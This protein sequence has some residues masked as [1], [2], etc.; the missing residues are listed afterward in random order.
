MS[1]KKTNQLY[2]KNIGYN[3]EEICPKEKILFLDIETTGLSPRSSYIYMIGA[4]H[5]TEASGLEPEGYTITQ[6]LAENA[7]DEK[8]ILV[9]FLSE[10][11]NYE[12]LIHFNGNTF[13]LPFIQARCEANGLEFNYSEFK[14]IDIYR[15]IQPFKN[16]LRLGSCKQKAVEEYLGIDREDQYSGGQLVGVYK[17][18][19]KSA[20]R[21]AL[22]L[23]VTHNYEDVTGMLSILPIL[24]YSDFLSGDNI[25]VGKVQINTYK[26]VNGLKSREL[27]INLTLSS[28]L[29]KP[30]SYNAN[31]CILTARA[32]EASLKVPVYDEE[33][34]YFYEGYKDYYYLPEEDMAVHKSVSIYVD[35]EFR[36]QATASTCYTRKKSSYLPEWGPLFNPFFKRDYETKSMFFELN[37]EFK[38]NKSSFIDYAKHILDM[39]MRNK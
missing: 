21:K 26:D 5:Y 19:V 8:E 12:M 27:L 17:E 13:D 7:A 32:N 33:M 9:D 31:E 22:K 18:Y 16:I 28:P 36:T 34:K 25:K 11:K 10:V 23:L 29:P 3:L 30:L 14:G 1:M 6:W 38:K 35:K 24:A 39:M 2:E 4:A 37:D 15:R 20:D